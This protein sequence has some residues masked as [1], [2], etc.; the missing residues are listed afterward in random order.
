M[1][2]NFW[3]QEV[4]FI[5]NKKIITAQA[6][7]LRDFLRKGPSRQVLVFLSTE[8]FGAGPEGIIK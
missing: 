6:R 8:P 2:F 4:E 1:K 7:Y 5:I 3:S